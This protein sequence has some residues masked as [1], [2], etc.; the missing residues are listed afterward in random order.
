MRSGTSHI[1]KHLNILKDIH[2][3]LQLRFSRQNCLQETY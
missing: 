1:W 3:L 2:R